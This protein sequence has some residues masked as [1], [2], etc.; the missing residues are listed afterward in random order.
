MSVKQ[1]D[2]SD[3]SQNAIHFILRLF[4]DRRGTPWFSS[5]KCV[6][7]AFECFAHFW[8]VSE[9]N[10]F[11]RHLEYLCARDVWL[12]S[13]AKGTAGEFETNTDEYSFDDSWNLESCDVIKMSPDKLTWDQFFMDHVTYCKFGNFRKGFIFAN[14]VKRIFAMLKIHNQGMIYPYQ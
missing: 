6:L 4:G 13:G 9:W 10:Y 11:L 3:S 12:N 8:L 14:S 5:L 7:I 1:S 2:K